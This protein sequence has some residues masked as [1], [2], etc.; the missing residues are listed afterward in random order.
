MRKLPAVLLAAV[1]A[2]PVLTSVLSLP[3]GA[4][5]APPARGGPRSSVPSVAPRAV[6]GPVATQVR[7]LSL[8]GVDPAALSALS[9]RSTEPGSRGA[10]GA[11]ARAA[12]SAPAVL[13]RAMATTAYQTLGVTWKASATEP[14]LLI[15]VRNRT[16]TGWSGWNSLDDDAGDDPASHV[17]TT[18]SVGPMAAMPV[19]RDGTDPLWVGPSTGVQVRIVV[20]SGRLPADLKVELVDPGASGHDAVAVASTPKG[21][22]YSAASANKPLVL[23]RAQWGADESRVRYAP[24][25]M[26][27]IKAAV[28]H[29]TAG[30]NNY[31]ASQVPSIIRGDYAYHLSRGW[32]D[33]GYNAL[34][35]RFGRIWE[36][37][38][39]GLDL[40]VM[41]AHAGGFNT[42]TFGVAMLGNYDVS[43]PTAAS[44]SAVAR[45]MAWKLDLDHRDPFGTTRL[46]SAGGGTARYPAGRTVTLPVI[47][48]HRNTGF[49]AC[50]GRYLYP[51]LGSIRA[52]ARTLMKASLLDPVGA[53]A[54][55]LRGTAVSLTARA[56]AAQT[57]SL[58][59]AGPPGGG[60]VA[61]ISGS[62]AA[63]KAIKATWNGRLTG[64][65]PARPGRYRLTLSSSSARGTARP[66]AD[67]VLVVPPAPA[68]Q[69][70]AVPSA[71]TGG[72]FPVTP[73]RVLDTRTDGRVG[74]GPAGRD[75]IPVLGRAGVP[76]TGVT[77]VVLNLTAGGGSDT[78]ALSVWPT[79]QTL[80]RTLTGVPAGQTRSVLVTSRVGG[81]GS[82]SVG[83]SRGVTELTADV[84]G[85]FAAG[86][87]SIQPIGSTRLYD[88]RRDPA[89]GLVADQ[90]RPVTLPAILA[91]R[92]VEQITG[93]VVDVSVLS[94][95]GAGTLTAYQPGAAGDLATLAF[96]AGES[97][98]NLAFVPVSGG[99]IALRSTG[100]AVNAVLDVRAVLTVP[101]AGTVPGGTVPG[102]TGLTLIKPVLAVDTRTTGGAVVAGRPRRLV[103]TGTRTGVPETASAVLVNLVALK[104]ATTTW[105]QVY[106]WGQPSGGGTALRVEKG[107]LRGNPVVVPIGPGG[108]ITIANA[109]DGVQVRVD[110]YGY[111][112]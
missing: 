28:L 46:L 96:G 15:S 52:Q 98:D 93:L 60:Q 109:R 45:V 51:Y 55:V 83:N 104:P 92:P 14:D 3:A 70:P 102:G 25:Y 39:G 112:S 105:L 66:F 8:S 94:P 22:D 107:E 82:V 106:A 12:T 2:V 88:S 29:H 85:Y 11:A 7:Q 24:T 67:T 87:S 53:P 18:E 27:T 103:V 44:I 19:V 74:L 50:P 5:A 100:P 40:A 41:G 97:M 71:G 80:T 32:S 38:G 9:A 21:G 91:G 69:I 37:R 61:R 90:P 110:V 59:V 77:S 89:G 17:P 111:L 49:T 62:A 95:T 48:G 6:A 43:R 16:A 64:G 56:L 4:S 34:V 31:S 30:L 20:R 81:A 33:I 101:A 58:D 23:S 65:E 79:G 86:G 54:S 75:D 26:P 76:A 63:G 35:D 13:T 108:A 68:A 57:W 78:T 47:M 1:T 72:Y 99:A 84:V 36:G 10:P 73:T 42:G